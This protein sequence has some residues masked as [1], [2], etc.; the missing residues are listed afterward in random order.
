MLLGNINAACDIPCKTCEI[1]LQMK[2]SAVYLTQ[3]E[4][5]PP[6]TLVNRAVAFYSRQPALFKITRFLYRFSG[7]KYINNKLH[8]W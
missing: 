4:I 1:Y 5:D 8:N 7:L 6:L 2:K 3:N